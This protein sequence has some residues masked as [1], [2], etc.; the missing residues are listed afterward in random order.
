MKDNE[1]DIWYLQFYVDL[2]KNKAYSATSNFSTIGAYDS[3]NKTYEYTIPKEKLLNFN[4]VDSYESETLV[5]QDIAEE[6]G[7]NLICDL[8]FPVLEG[9]VLRFG[10]AITNFLF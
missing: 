6:T 1:T 5:P 2:E 10:T 4:E 8:L 9:E 3:V 7:E